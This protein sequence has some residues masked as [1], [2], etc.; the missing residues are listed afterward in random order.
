M[1]RVEHRVK[2]AILRIAPSALVEK[3]AQPVSLVAAGSAPRHAVARGSDS[4]EDAFSLDGPDDRL[5]TE[6]ALLQTAASGH[7]S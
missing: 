5:R 6:R 4:N 7:K 1:D 2:G 3:Q